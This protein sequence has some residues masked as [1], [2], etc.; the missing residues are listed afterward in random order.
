MTPTQ[1]RVLE[2]QNEGVRERAV[3]GVRDEQPQVVW[4]VQDGVEGCLVLRQPGGRPAEPGAKTP[5]SQPWT[6]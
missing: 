5:W 6:S 4:E 1:R 3:Q 2:V